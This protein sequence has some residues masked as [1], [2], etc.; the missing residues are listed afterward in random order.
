MAYKLIGQDCLVQTRLGGFVSGQPISF[1][2]AVPQ[3]WLAKSIEL[4]ELAIDADVTSLGDPL[5]KNRC[6]RRSATV[7]LKLQVSDAGP[8]FASCTGFA[9]MVEIKEVSS[10]ILERAYVG[11]I[12]RASET[13]EDGETIETVE[14]KV[15]IDGWNYTGVY[16]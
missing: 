12:A 13:I 3:L 4:D 6:K 9:L 16:W 14:V 5:E 2:T 1:N 8:Q 7:R 15:G 11:M 10:M